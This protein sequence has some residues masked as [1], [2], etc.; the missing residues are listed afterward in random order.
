MEVTNLDLFLVYFKYFMIA[1]FAMLTLTLGL[2]YGNSLK[3]I[4]L[5]ASVVILMIFSVLSL[6]YVFASVSVYKRDW[7][8]P[9]ELAF[10]NDDLI[11][12]T[13]DRMYKDSGYGSQRFSDYT[14]VKVNTEDF[15]PDIY[16]LNTYLTFEIKVIDNSV[17]RTFKFDL[18]GINFTGSNYQRYIF[19]KDIDNQISGDYLNKTNRYNW[20]NKLVYD[21]INDHQQELKKFNNSYDIQ[22]QAEFN[23][24]LR[25]HLNAY[26]KE[27]GIELTK[28]IKFRI[29]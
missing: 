3:M 11:I 18:D 6:Y 29:K 19:A 7:H 9:H 8:G 13:K 28:Q 20:I 4:N 14:W 15:C 10:L 2:Y 25:D 17:I 26:L 16:N 27:Y 1:S 23:M 24:L 12:D 21:F 5:K 22:Q